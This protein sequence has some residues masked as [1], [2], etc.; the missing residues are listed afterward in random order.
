VKFNASQYKAAKVKRFGFSGFS[1]DWGM[2]SLMLGS[3]HLTGNQTINLHFISF[4][5][6]SVNAIRRSG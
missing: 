6:V 4:Q 3:Q 5:K 1:M 2:N